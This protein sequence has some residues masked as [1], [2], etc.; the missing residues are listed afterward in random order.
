MADKTVV[1][2]GALDTKGNELQLVKE[3]VADRGLD[4]IVVDFGVLGE[5]AFP[6]DVTR[7]EVA[8]AGGGDIERLRSGQQKDEA[9]RAMSEGLV[10]VA[11]RLYEEGRL[12]GILAMG[13]GGSTSIATAAM[14]ALPVGVPKLMVS[15]LGGG[16]VSAFAGTKDITFM[17]SVVDVAGFNPISR[18]I[19]ANAAGAIAGMVHAGRP[20]SGGGKP[21]IGASMFG[22]TTPAVD[23]AR[24]RLE[25]RG[26]EVVVFHATG[27]GGRTMEDLVGSGYFKG[28]LD[29]T[30]TELA[31]EVCGGVIERGAAA[32]P[33][34][35]VGRPSRR[36]SPRLCRHGQLRTPRHGP[37]ALPGP[38]ALRMEPE[39]HPPADQPGG[40]RQDRPA[41]CRSSQCG[42]GTGDCAPA[43]QRRVPA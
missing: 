7:A 20:T 6:P 35:A 1:L 18:L 15:T 43:L 19:Y 38:L 27:T 31:D 42:E 33:G 21:L 13:G 34:G 22:N 5:P 39:R 26:Y 2:V 37:R 3:L 41:A 23:R 36:P 29:I 40:E 28:V 32:R 16:D 14:R 12:Q 30:T 25:A 10:A 11:R 17:P 9:M 24:A 8:A 4:V